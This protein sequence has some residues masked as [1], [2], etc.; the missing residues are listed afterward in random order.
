MVPKEPFIPVARPALGKEEWEATRT[1]FESGWVTSGPE[2]EA[3][4][5]EFARAHGVEHA[6]AVSS[7]TTALHLALEVSGIGPGDEVIVPSFTWVATANSVLYVGATPVFVDI[8]LQ[9]FNININLID[10]KLSP[11]TKAIMLVHQFGLCVDVSEVKKRYPEL[12]LVED[13]ACASGSMVGESFAGSLGDIACFSF[14]PRKLITTG[15]GGMIT[16][17]DKSKAEELRSLRSHAMLPFSR[18]NGSQI[19]EFGS[20]GYNFRMSDILAA[21]G[22]L[23]LRKLDAMIQERSQLAEEYIN[24]LAN[25]NWIKTPR[26]PEGY[27]H[28]W[29][30]FVI[31]I[32]DRIAPVRRDAFMDLLKKDQ[33]G[34]RPGTHSIALLPYFQQVMGDSN[35]GL[36]SASEAHFQSVALP[37]FNGM[38]AAELMRVCDSIQRIAS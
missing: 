15:E 24:R 13:A 28:A 21:V 34:T 23:Q 31:L 6:V 14:H 36:E 26:Q 10:Q 17:R 37:L 9:T 11:R 5:K 20:L 12:V 8:D 32:D 16:T 22:R 18:I 4:E 35:E 2:V 33:I 3:F 29:Q 30:S 7:G 1:V 38:S 27:K 25:I 19:P